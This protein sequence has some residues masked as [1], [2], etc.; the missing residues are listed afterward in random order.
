MRD[1][2]CDGEGC[3]EAEQA[4]LRH[5]HHHHHHL[6]SRGIIGAGSIEPGGLFEGRDIYSENTQYA[7]K[8]FSFWSTGW[9]E[10][11]CIAGGKRCIG[12]SVG[13]FGVC[14]EGGLYAFTLL[15]MGGE[16]VPELGYLSIGSLGRRHWR[17]THSGFMAHWLGGRQLIV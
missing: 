8:A 10:K 13:C 15:R 11:Q 6:L 5:H 17:C 14:K 3:E 4:A 7:S 9:A 1:W 16:G 2:R 12:A